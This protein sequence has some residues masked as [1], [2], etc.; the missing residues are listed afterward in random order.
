MGFFSDSKEDH[1]GGQVKNTVVI[2][3]KDDLRVQSNEILF[4]LIVIAVLVLIIVILRV[5][6]I[7]KKGTKRQ[8]TRDQILLN[9]M[10]AQQQ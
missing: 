8:A 6:S 3:N 9:R 4:M 2:G 5:V 10:P 1:T 7:I